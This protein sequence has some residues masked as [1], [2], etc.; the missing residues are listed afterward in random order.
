[1]KFILL[2]LI[3]FS[4]FAQNSHMSPQRALNRLSQSDLLIL[5]RGKISGISRTT[6]SGYNDTVDTSFEDLWNEGGALTYPT[7]AETIRIKS[8]GNVNDTAAGSGCRSVLVD[9]LSST[10]VEQNDTLATAGSSASSA[11]TNTYIAI[12]E[13]TCVTTGTFNTANTE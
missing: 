3:T 12:N 5:S 10:F 1:M 8:G 6:V 2:F 13:V 11:T 7:V 4:A 9:G